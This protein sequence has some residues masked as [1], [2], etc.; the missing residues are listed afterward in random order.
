VNVIR[1]HYVINNLEVS[2]W[3]EWRAAPEQARAVDDREATLLDSLAKFPECKFAGITPD[4]RADK[5][6]CPE[7]R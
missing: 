1:D 2:D 5:L 3:D 6:A 7:P 4:W